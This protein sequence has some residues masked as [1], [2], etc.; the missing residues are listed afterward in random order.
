MPTL[1]SK[2]S[3]FKVM[4]EKILKISLNR[5]KAHLKNKWKDKAYRNRNLLMTMNKLAFQIKIMKKVR[6]NTKNNI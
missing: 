3:F 1:R 5:K 6:K 4:L 2:S